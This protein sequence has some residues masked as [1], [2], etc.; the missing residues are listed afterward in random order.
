MEML[1]GDPLDQL[2]RKNGSLEWR[3]AV[4]LAIQA[5]R[6]LEAAHSAGV[7]HRDIK[8]A[9]LFV[10]RSGLV[11]LLDFG[12]AHLRQ[13]PEPRETKTEAFEI[14]GTPEY[15]AP[16]QAT[17]AEPTAQSDVYAL[18]SV[19]YEMLT[20]SQPFIA[21]SITA[22]IEAKRTETPLSVRKCLS[23][24]EAPRS[25]DRV[26]TRTLA[27][28]LERRFLSVQDLRLAL[29][30][31][32]DSTAAIRQHRS[33]RVTRLASSLALLGLLTAGAL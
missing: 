7:I 25:L 9:N 20:G 3:S 8:P 26:L 4:T 33:L 32:L 15:M 14:F 17:G 23:G 6:A 10:T 30:A 18:G 11:K 27:A 5:C 12:I 13:Q 31:V 16:E 24:A 19:L 21:E 2:L 29:E 28:N 1:R 22:L